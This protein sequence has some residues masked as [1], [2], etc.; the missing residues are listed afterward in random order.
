ME[1]II[2]NITRYYFHITS[3]CLSVF[4]AL[5]Q[6]SPLKK[7]KPSSLVWFLNYSGSMGYNAISWTTR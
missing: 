2:Y 4:N 6:N 7:A 1:Y 3:Y 5:M